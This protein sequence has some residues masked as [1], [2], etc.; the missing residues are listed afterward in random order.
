MEESKSGATK[1]TTGSRGGNGSSSDDSSLFKKPLPKS[2][3]KS[4]DASASGSQAKGQKRPI[5]SSSASGSSGDGEKKGIVNQVLSGAWKV[6]RSGTQFFV[7]DKTSSGKKSGKKLSKKERKRAA[8]EEYIK[9]VLLGESTDDDEV[10]DDQDADAD[11]QKFFVSKLT[12]AAAMAMPSTALKH[13]KKKMDHMSD[14]LNDVI[15]DL[16]EQLAIVSPITTAAREDFD[17]DS[18]LALYLP[19][20]TLD[21]LSRFFEDTLLVGHLSARFVVQRMDTL[22]SVRKLNS[23]VRNQL[24]HNNLVARV[25]WDGPK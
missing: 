18:E 23:A 16:L 14:E 25:R 19:F 4:G 17:G 21:S 6:S 12:T 13:E 2:P 15:N 22:N 5:S 11:L 7:R 10:E 1:R 3:K 24:F 20:T 9:S 8:E